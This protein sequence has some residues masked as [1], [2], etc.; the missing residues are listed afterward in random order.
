M[1]PKLT[2]KPAIS[3]GSVGLEA[4]FVERG[5]DKQE[6][7]DAHLDMLNDKLEN[8]EFDLIA[9]GRVLLSD[10]EWP[11]KVQEGRN[12]DIIPLQVKY[13]PSYTKNSLHENS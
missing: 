3:V 2:G 9:L 1:D 6:T 5:S 10:P 7:G 11:L 8:E 13:Y 12:A 4:E